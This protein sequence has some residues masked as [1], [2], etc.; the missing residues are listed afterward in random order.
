MFIGNLNRHQQSVFLGF[1]E[2]V[3]AADGIV[4]SEE[5]AMMTIIKSQMLPDI[6]KEEA[7]VQEIRNIFDTKSARASMIL[8]LFGL[9]YADQDDHSYDSEKKIIQDVASACCISEMELSDMESW[10]VHQLALVREAN[11]F[12]GE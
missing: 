6:V 10:V 1:A 3:V 4:S 12:M 2:Q 9:A 7:E 8:E 5:E 11:Q